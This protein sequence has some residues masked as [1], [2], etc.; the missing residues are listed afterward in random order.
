MLSCYHIHA[1]FPA[2]LVG[3]TEPFIL[4]F[5]EDAHLPEAQF[6]AVGCTICVVLW[7]PLRQLPAT[8]LFQEGGVC[9]AVDCSGSESFNM[10]LSH[11]SLYLYQH[12]CFSAVAGYCALCS[13][14]VRKT[15]G[16]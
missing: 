10:G 12:G 2:N 1:S 13:G 14:W 16:E 15:D 3:L 7:L 11:Y 6:E 8:E 4:G 5:L 9:L